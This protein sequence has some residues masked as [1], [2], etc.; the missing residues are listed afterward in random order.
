MSRNEMSLA[1]TCFIKAVQLNTT[2]ESSRKMLAVI[3]MKQA[4]YEKALKTMEAAAQNGT[5]DAFFWKNIGVLQKY[6]KINP[7]EAGKDFNRYLAL[8][9]DSYGNR[10]KREMGDG[11]KGF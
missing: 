8:G 5:R 3:Y 4:S 11:K 6:Y 10:I 9:G 2:M 1:E 7:T